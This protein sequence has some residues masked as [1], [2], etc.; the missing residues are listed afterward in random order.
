MTTQALKLTHK[1]LEQLINDRLD[2][3][4]FKVTFDDIPMYHPEHVI[5]KGERHTDYMEVDDGRE[6]RWLIFTDTVTGKEHHL[7]YTYNKEYP[8]DLFDTPDSIEVVEKEE[9]SD[10]YVAPEPVAIPEEVLSPEKQASKDLWDAYDAIKHECK[11]VAPKEK[12]S[13]P[14]QRI[15]EILALLKTSWSMPELH[16][17]FVPVCIEYKIEHVSFWKWIQ[18]KRKVWKA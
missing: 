8:N 5:Q 10:I 1:E 4:R 11:V 14:K 7:N 9:E 13:V 2:S 18:V 16:A 12:L 17:V 6:Y 3:E 15:D